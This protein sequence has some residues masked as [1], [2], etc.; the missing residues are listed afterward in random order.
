[1]RTETIL[2]ATCLTLAL[3]LGA[4]GAEETDEP[5]VDTP[6]AESPPPE[7]EAAPEERTDDETVEEATEEAEPTEDTAEAPAAGEGDHCAQA[8]DEIQ[9]MIRQL[10]EQLGPGNGRQGP[11]RSEFLAGCRELPASVQPC[12]RMSYVMEHQQECQ[13]AQQSLDPETR[14]RVQR[15]MGRGD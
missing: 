10:Q 15:L 7:A 14:A 9:E 8:Y 4:C 13:Q 1:M 2:R 5:V 12:M 6:A 11:S 3:A